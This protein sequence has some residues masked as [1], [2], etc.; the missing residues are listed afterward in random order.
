[1]ALGAVALIAGVGFGLVRAGND[2]GGPA[3]AARD[4]RIELI[5]VPEGT[6]ATVALDGRASDLVA[7]D[8]CE[9][10]APR[11]VRITAPEVGGLQ[12]TD[13]CWVGGRLQGDDGV[14]YYFYK[15]AV[16]RAGGGTSAP[17][18][19]DGRFTGE[20]LPSGIPINVVDVHPDD[21]YY[22]YRTEI[23]GKQCRTAGTL[24]KTA[25]GWMA[26]AVFCPDEGL[27]LYFYKVAVKR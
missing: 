5:G 15:A 17:A 26:G 18:A 16:R 2:T 9:A 23:V 3:V 25:P 7:G 8:G 13:A 4:V 22:G 14:D 19:G 20:S 24:T 12:R 21:A 10:T 1:M 11:P 6:A 27:Q